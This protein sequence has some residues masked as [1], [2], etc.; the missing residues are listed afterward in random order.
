MK[1]LLTPD[2]IN[3]A[4]DCGMRYAVARHNDDDT[5]YVLAQTDEYRTAWAILKL[6]TSKPE[7]WAVYDSLLG[8]ELAEGLLV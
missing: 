1:T 7:I 4:L 5:F 3:D 8:A 6:V 2:R